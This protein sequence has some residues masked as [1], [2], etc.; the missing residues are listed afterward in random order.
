MVVSSGK[1][2]SGT[3]S[4]YLAETRCA[5]KAM[6]ILRLVEGFRDV[7]ASTSQP[8]SVQSDNSFP[9]SFWQRHAD[10]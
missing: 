6:M 2:L 8:L 7:F 9:I 1:T 5:L 3:R 10:S 4:H